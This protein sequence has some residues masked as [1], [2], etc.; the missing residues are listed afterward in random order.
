MRKGVGERRRSRADEA[1][2][3]VGRRPGLG[4]KVCTPLLGLVPFSPCQ[5]PTVFERMPLGNKLKLRKREVED[6]GAPSFP[7]AHP[8]A[9]D[10]WP[11]WQGIERGVPY[12]SE[13]AFGRRGNKS[14]LQ[15]LCALEN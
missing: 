5:L 14:R 3:R 7:G 4:F 2:R 9:Q 1:R 12:L 8:H 6:S 13:P 15:H 10:P 11:E